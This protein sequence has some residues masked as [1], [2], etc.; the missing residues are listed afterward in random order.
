MSRATCQDPIDKST[1]SNDRK[2]HLSRRRSSSLTA[3]FLAG[4]QH[5]LLGPD[6][7]ALTHRPGQTGQRR[8][9]LTRAH[10]PE[11]DSRTVTRQARNSGHQISR[12]STS[13]VVKPTRKACHRLFLQ[14]S[15]WSAWILW[16]SCLQPTLR[17]A[18]RPHYFR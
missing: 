3:S 7:E 4:R 11:R 1:R 10:P 8:P 15:V 6:P 14:H 18:V 12:P 16:S 9:P 2:A 13:G 5:H 17:E